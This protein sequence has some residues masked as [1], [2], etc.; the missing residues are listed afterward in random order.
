[1]HFVFLYYSTGHMELV[2]CLA[3]LNES[4]MLFGSQS[5]V[6]GIEDAAGSAFMDSACKPF[7]LL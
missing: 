3:M 7:L 4:D 1:M 6:I 2:F 5:R